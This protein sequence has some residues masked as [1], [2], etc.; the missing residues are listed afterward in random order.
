MQHTEQGVWLYKHCSLTVEEHHS[1][2]L[3]NFSAGR[4]KFLDYCITKQGELEGE[5]VIPAAAAGTVKTWNY[6]PEHKIKCTI[7]NL[8]NLQFSQQHL[9][10]FWS[11]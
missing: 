5:G 1:Q 6:I 2:H 10:P 8:Y 7:K 3:H 11:S 4:M 9:L